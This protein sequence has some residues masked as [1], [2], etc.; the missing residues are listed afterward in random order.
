[1]L[2]VQNY[3]KTQKDAVN[4]MST[5][6]LTNEEAMRVATRAKEEEQRTKLRE[7]VRILEAI[8]SENLNNIL[9]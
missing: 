8:G 6:G 1:M 7:Q 5:Q 4:L 9:V 3:L 2:D